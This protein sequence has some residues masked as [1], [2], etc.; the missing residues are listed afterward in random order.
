MSRGIQRNLKSS[1]P[2]ETT[3]NAWSRTPRYIA[4]TRSSTTFTNSKLP[5]QSPSP[6][7]ALFLMNKMLPLAT[8][9]PDADPKKTCS[10]PRPTDVFTSS[11][12]ISAL[13]ISWVAMPSLTSWTT[14]LRP[15]TRTLFFC[16][17][18]EQCPFPCAVRASPW[19]L[20]NNRAFWLH[21]MRP[22]HR[23][24]LTQPKTRFI[25]QPK[26][27]NTICEQFRK[28]HSPTHSLFTAGQS[29]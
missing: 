20:P 11:R 28:S 24:C 15:P 13:T 5:R 22:W 3:R 7:F 25:I 18:R 8:G 10:H 19:Q 29:V 6:S 2:S 16:S 26:I 17:R 9:P 21:P 4:F 14:G 23:W 27:T 1:R 12:R